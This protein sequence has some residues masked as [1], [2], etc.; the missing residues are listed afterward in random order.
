M[1]TYLSAE[2]LAVHLKIKRNTVYQWVW[3]R[4]IPF[5]KVGGRVLFLED[6]VERLIKKTRKEAVIAKRK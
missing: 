5:H 2:E 4:K 1:T 6:E 3:Q